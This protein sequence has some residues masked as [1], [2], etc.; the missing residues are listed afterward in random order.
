MHSKVRLIPWTLHAYLQY[1]NPHRWTSI[2]CASAFCLANL[3]AWNAS[4]ATNGLCSKAAPGC[5]N[6]LMREIEAWW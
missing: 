5:L 1:Q 2:A 3:R 4:D 6:Q